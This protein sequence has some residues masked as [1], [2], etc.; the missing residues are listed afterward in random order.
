MNLTTTA[1]KSRCPNGQK[2]NEIMAADSDQTLS[3]RR[4]RVTE[5]EL[6]MSS[7]VVNEATQNSSERS[8]RY[9]RSRAEACSSNP[10]TSVDRPL[11]GDSKQKAKTDGAASR[12]SPS[13]DVDQ[14]K[15]INCS[16]QK[17][18]KTER[19]EKTG[20]DHIN[21][22]TD[23][24]APKSN[25]K[26]RKIR[27]GYEVY[28]IKRGKYSEKININESEFQRQEK[29]KENKKEEQV[30]KQFSSNK[31]RKHSPKGVKIRNYSEESKT[32][33][34]WEST[35]SNAAQQSENW[36]SEN[37]EIKEPISGLSYAEEN[38]DKEAPSVDENAEGKV[39]SDIKEKSYQ[40]EESVESSSK[41]SPNT[42]ENV[43]ENASPN[44]KDNVVENE[45]KNANLHVKNE[46]AEN[47]IEESNKDKS[48]LQ[49]KD[50]K[51]GSGD[52]SK[53]GDGKLEK[54]KIA[55]RSIEKNRI[56]S[57]RE[58]NP[59]RAVK[60]GIGRGR[61]NKPPSNISQVGVKGLSKKGEQ[62]AET[63]DK[64]DI[65][66]K[67]TKDDSQLL[68]KSTK[69]REK[70]QESQQKTAVVKQISGENVSS[71][72][73]VKRKVKF[74]DDQSIETCN[75]NVNDSDSSSN[76]SRTAGILVLPSPISEGNRIPENATREDME[77]KPHTQA[78]KRENG[79]SKLKKPSNFDPSQPRGDAKF[80][81]ENNQPLLV[82]KKD[83]R[84][85]SSDAKIWDRIN[86]EC[87]ELKKLL[88]GN[89]TSIDDIE[90]ILELSTLLQDLYKE[91]I[92]KHL[93]FSFKNDIEGSLWKNTFHNIITAFRSILNEQ[94]TSPFLNEAFQFYWNFL[95]DGDDF[96]KD[97][98]SLIEEECKFN[99]QSFVNNP[100]KMANC[101]KN[102]RML[103]MHFIHQ[104]HQ[105]YQQH[106]HHHQISLSP[107]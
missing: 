96:L 92:V 39:N 41:T 66:S 90:K 57:S 10:G 107:T 73:A 40:L 52:P 6:E 72:K 93:E 34:K 106:H 24:N 33:G 76:K 5:K 17:F 2:S 70:S 51:S 62:A 69:Q 100:L 103:K 60:R 22:S 36:D 44:T 25:E 11:S 45:Y 61:K 38:W 18:V 75:E 42:K 104:H 74:S 84:I 98:L 83:M 99:L 8:K 65:I 58:Q 68:E 82:R 12:D 101:K 49:N 15:Q 48:L 97:L 59:Q 16:S 78:V 31:D 19:F 47:K 23:I 30:R 86:S 28:Q 4:I 55:N 3:F 64:S 14:M 9:S 63:T 80:R 54:E 29:G 32:D 67:Q 85:S 27:K 7:N 87:A 21:D 26:P 91:L 105:Y 81:K 88:S 89:L 46:L 102:V 71:D 1:T 79:F 94:E 43:T 13:K 35:D 95:Q 37:L 20:N 56:H 50:N 53:E 77:P